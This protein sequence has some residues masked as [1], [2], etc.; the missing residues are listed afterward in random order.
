MAKRNM[1]RQCP[2]LAKKHNPG[3]CY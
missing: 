3:A 2:T 1:K